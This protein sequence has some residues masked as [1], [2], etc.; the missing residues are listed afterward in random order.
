M[1]PRSIA[2]AAGLAALARPSLADAACDGDTACSGGP[3]R[4]MIVV[5]ASSD[6][7]NVGNAAGGM[8]LT[9]WDVTRTVLAAATGDTLYDAPVQPPGPVASQVV[10]FGVAVFGNPD[11]LEQRVLVDYAPCSRPRVDW[12][13]DPISSCVEPGCTDPWAGP[14][15]MWTSQRG[16]LIDPPGFNS[17]TTSHMPQCSGPGMACT[18]S[19]RFVAPILDQITDGRMPYLDSTPF[20]ADGTTDFVN[21]LLV[22]GEYEDDDTT[23]QTSLEEAFAAGITTYVIGIGPAADNPNA[24]FDMQLT[25]MADW[26]S[27][28]T[29]THRLAPNAGQLDTELQQIVAGHPLPCCESIDCSHVGGADGGGADG[30][31]GDTDGAADWGGQDGTADGAVDGGADASATGGAGSATVTDTETGGALDDDGGCT[32]RAT[33]KQRP[34]GWAAMGVLLIGAVR[35]RR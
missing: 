1:R 30:T 21:F 22:A 6:M 9:P 8:G 18:G 10:H 4:I 14:D 7:L 25:N 3:A 26:G 2:L 27:G 35:R 20:V 13:L 12:A 11:S 34:L 5:D 19:G 16:D 23:V 28:G 33:P 15:I 32:C 24:T 29:A 31:A 17:P